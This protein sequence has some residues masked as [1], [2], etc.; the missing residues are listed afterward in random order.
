MMIEIQVGQR[1]DNFLTTQLK[2]LPKSRLYRALRTGEVRVNGRRVSPDY[3]LEKGDQVRIPPLRLATPTEPKKPS[4]PFLEKLASAIMLEN[5][6]FIV[7]N[8]PAGV[9]SH[10]GSG[11]QLG[12]VE[13]FKYLRPQAKCIGLAHRLDRYTTGCLILA[14]KP[15][16]LKELHR[17]FLVGKIQKTYLAWVSGCWQG[18]EKIV[19]KP[20]RKNTLSS[21]ERVVRIHPEGKEARTIFKPLRVL[22]DQKITLVEAVPLTGRTHQIR[23]HAAAIGYPILGDDKYGLHGP[24]A[25]SVKHLMLHAVSID[26]ELNGHKFALCACLH[27]EF[28]SL[29]R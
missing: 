3:R 22:E 29:G 24:Q 11:I 1:I 14:K 2:G 13:G 23:V 16:V 17:L 5:K 21:G 19:N 6:D 9:A 20:L 28:Q 15:S 12:V 7:L 8:K 25:L 18:G 10:G 4:F 26:F 27:K